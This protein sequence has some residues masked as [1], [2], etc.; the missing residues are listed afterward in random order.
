MV[1]FNVNNLNQLSNVTRTATMTVAG[2]ASGAA[3]SVTVN[4][5][6]AS[7]YGDKTFARIGTTLVNGNNTFTNIA[8]DS[9]GR[10][11]TNSV[12]LN[13]PT[14]VSFEYDAKGNMTSDARRG[15]EFDDENQL[16][17]IT[18]TNAWKTEFSY[19][20]LFRRRIRR[21]HTWNGSWVLA[22]TAPIITPT[23]TGTSHA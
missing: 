10:K 21:E 13:L 22:Q 7:L 2:N 15:F 11:D 9:A 3:T 17:R 8:T 6:A 5:V 20:G 16:T 18:V 4:G 14:P 12:T 19:D 23:A 1:T